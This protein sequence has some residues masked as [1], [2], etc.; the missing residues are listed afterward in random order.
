MHKRYQQGHHGHG[1]GHGH[2]RLCLDPAGSHPSHKSHLLHGCLFVQVV[3]TVDNQLTPIGNVTFTPAD[4]NIPQRIS[5]QCIDD[6]EVEGSHGGTINITVET[7][8]DINYNALAARPPL[9]LGVTIRDNDCPPLVA[10]RNAVFSQVLM[11][12]GHSHIHGHGHGHGPA[13]TVTVTVTVRKAF[14]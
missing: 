2:G 7:S 9:S 11:G 12:H 4:W 1:H 10:P 6:D 8:T 5:I 13:V 3:I 14:M